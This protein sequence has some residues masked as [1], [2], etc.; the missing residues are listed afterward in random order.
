MACSRGT[1]SLVCF[2]SNPHLFFKIGTPFS[3]L[4]FCPFYCRPRDPGFRYQQR[5]N[6][7]DSNDGRNNFN[8]THLERTENSS[9]QESVTPATVIEVSQLSETV[10][11]LL[12]KVED[13]KFTFKPGQWVDL[14][15]PGVSTVGGFTICSSP[16]ELKETSTV[17]LA[18]KYSEHPPALWVHTKCRVGSKVHMR[19]GGDFYFDPNPD[20]PSPDLLLVAGGVGINPVYSILQHVADIAS[21]PLYQYTGKTT[22]LYSAKNQD[23]LLFK[24]SLMK[25]SKKCP[26][27]LCKFFVTK[28]ESGGSTC[29]SNFYVFTVIL[30]SI[31]HARQRY[32]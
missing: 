17:E 21:D 18:I 14:F 13:N 32:M 5:A 26:S 31:F 7:S 9:R 22:L 1:A 3:R 16:R 20:D 12:L 23:E 29:M 19:V 8:S 4:L 10:K 2:W 25:I 27:I 15:I 30:L 11:R 6:S 24:D 28:P